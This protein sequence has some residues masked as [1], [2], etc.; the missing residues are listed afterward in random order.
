M[1]KRIKKKKKRKKK[2]KKKKTVKSP[3][4]EQ[5]KELPSSRLREESFLQGS[6]EKS[7]R[8]ELKGVPRPAALN[9]ENEKS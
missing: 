8:A 4:V 5:R 6:Q 1:P 2:K 7:R 9:R 3:A